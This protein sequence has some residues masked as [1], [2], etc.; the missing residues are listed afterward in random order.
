MLSQVHSS[1]ILGIHAYLTEIEIDIHK[2][3]PTVVVVGLPDTSVK[4][5]KERI[6]SALENSGF[7]YPTK[8][9]TINLAPADTKKEGP[10]FDLPIAIGILSASSQLSATNLKDYIITGELALDGKVRPIHGA[11]SMALE[12]K[13]QGK[14][15]IIVPKDN[16]MEAAVVEGLEVFA[17]EH[18]RNITDFLEE[19]RAIAP[20]HLNKEKLFEQNGF[21]LSD[22]AD[23]KGQNFVKRALEI[24]AAGSHNIL[25]I[26]P[27]GSGKSMLAKCLPGILPKLG[28]DEALETT[29]IHSIV[30]TLPAEKALITQRPFRNPH[31]TISD[32]GLIGGGHYPRPGEASLAHHGVLFLDELPEFRRNVLEVLRQPIEEGSIMISRAKGSLQYPA[33]FMLVGAMNP[34]PCGYFSDPKKTCV[35]TP[36]QIQ[37][38]ISKISGPLLDRID[39]H[40][41]VPAVSTI[42]SFPVMSDSEFPE[43]AILMMIIME[44]T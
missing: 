20:L 6:K 14:R 44:P 7:S 2:G 1:A 38:Y 3:L 24:A 28:L 26:G 35:C 27:P 12:A 29:K 21:P 34:C 4:E 40:I 9:I 39:I 11:L 8:R 22:F 10:A 18:L 32:A 36:N 30:G 25:M 43:M 23:V 41:E 42:N 16:A 31:H 33:K 17:I 13:R 37:K 5:S 15:G 19:K